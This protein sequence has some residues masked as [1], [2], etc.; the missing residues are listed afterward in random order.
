MLQPSSPYPRPTLTPRADGLAKLA[1]LILEW[2]IPDE[3]NTTLELPFSQEKETALAEA[4][5]GD[6][7]NAVS[8]SSA[9]DVDASL[10][11][12]HRE[13]MPE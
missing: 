13:F 5:Q 12:K 6:T 9:I 7:A 11:P 10:T 4:L 8:A 1:E 3:S 2:R